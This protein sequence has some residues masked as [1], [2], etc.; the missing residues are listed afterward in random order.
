[1]ILENKGWAA[2][3]KP[4][5]VISDA[6]YVTMLYYNDEVIINVWK[7]KMLQF[8]NVLNQKLLSA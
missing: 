5:Q 6:F 2:R 8:S 7:N 3:L 4:I 1:M